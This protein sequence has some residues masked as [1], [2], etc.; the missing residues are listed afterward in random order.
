MDSMSKY[1]KYIAAVKVDGMI[2]ELISKKNQTD[3]LCLEAV[4]KTGLALQFVKKQ[5]QEVCSVA[6]KKCACALKYVKP[7]F[8]TYDMCLE[9]V[10]VDGYT[11]KY[12]KPRFQTRE[13]CLEAVKKDGSV[14]EFV[15]NQT[16]EICIIA[17]K[18]DGSWGRQDAF[19]AIKDEN[20]KKIID[21]IQEF[22]WDDETFEYIELN[23]EMENGFFD[24]QKEYFN[25]YCNRQLTKSCK[26]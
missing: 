25:D 7:R 8:Q 21:K 16:P 14:L 13:L 4:K 18:H 9:A 11:L 5:N 15:R 1:A 12:V 17:F 2:L 26:E 22:P 3:E 19:N 10:K 24:D 23:P 6:V 20:T